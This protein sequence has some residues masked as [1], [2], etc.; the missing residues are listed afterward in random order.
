MKC[1][2]QRVGALGQ[3]ET[4][5]DDFLPDLNFLRVED[6]SSPRTGFEEFFDLAQQ[7]GVAAGSDEAIFRASGVDEIVDGFPEP[8]REDVLTGCV[9][10]GQASVDEDSKRRV[11]G[12][13][14]LAFFFQRDLVIAFERVEHCEVFLTGRQ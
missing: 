8:V 9:S 6:D 1:W 13:L 5:E 2:V 12:C 14:H 7:D 11:E 10:H 3:L 4:S